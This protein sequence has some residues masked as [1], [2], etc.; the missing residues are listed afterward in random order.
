MMLVLPFGEVGPVS[1]LLSF[2]EMSVKIDNELLKEFFAEF[3]GFHFFWRVT[4]FKFPV[5]FLPEI[6]SNLC[7][8]VD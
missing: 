2:I 4:S 5:L 7:R 8:H 1:L 3:T 6:S